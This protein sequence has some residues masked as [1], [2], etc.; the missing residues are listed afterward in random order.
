[1]KKSKY[2]KDAIRN[3]CDGKRSSAEIAKIVGC[4]SKYVQELMLKENLPRLKSGPPRGEKNPAWKGGRHVDRD[5]YCLIPAP[6][7]HPYARRSGKKIG[8]ILEHRLVM[9]QTI[10]RYL[11]PTEV[12][13]HIDGNKL[14]N[15]PENLRLF[16]SNGQHLAQTLKGRTPNWSKSGRRNFRGRSAKKLK[17]HERIDTYRLRKETHEIREQSILRAR[18]LLGADSLYLLGMERFL[19]KKKNQSR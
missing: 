17:D 5:G 19:K 2:D 18:E 1:M 10:G 4:P 7:G 16:E 15:S 3:L 9:E 8:R 11:L 12:V 13:D 14:N 6:D